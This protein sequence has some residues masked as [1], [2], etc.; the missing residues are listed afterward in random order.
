MPMHWY[1][2]LIC[3][4]LLACSPGSASPQEPATATVI[5]ATETDAVQT[6]GVDSADDPAIWASPRGES[7]MLAGHEIKGF[8]AGTDKTAGLYI[9]GI[10]GRKLQ[11]LS[12]G[13]LNNVDLREMTLN[14]H[15][16]VVLGASDRGRGGIALYV[17]DAQSRS[18]DNAVRR[19][20]FIKSDVRQPYGLCMGKINNQLYTVLLSSRG[21]ARIHR[22][23]LNRLRG[24]GVEIDRFSLGSKSE[25]CVVDEAGH[26]LYIG[27]E[28]RGLW[29]YRLD[30]LGAPE[31]IEPAGR[32]VLTADIEGVTIIRDGGMR[33]LIA[34]SQGDNTFAVWRVD[35][36]SPRFAGRFSVRRSPK[37]D[38][39]T[40]TDGIDATARPIGPYQEGLLVVQDDVNENDG[41]NFKIVDWRLVRKAL[42]ATKTKAG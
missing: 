35:T 39:I 7:A 22:L 29:K 31:L 13:R 14:G 11:F 41:Q 38:E 17:F 15:N 28:N 4:P 34:S 9:F 5:A 3:L 33:Y 32:G 21:E 2:F 40:K 42:R 24:A 26:A 12:D 10:D 27:E 37:V 1:T 16:H 18:A 25:G 30:D 19:F 23:K 20:G 6:R 8:I 36:G